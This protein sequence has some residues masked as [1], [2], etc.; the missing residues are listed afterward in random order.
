MECPTCNNITH[1]VLKIAI[2]KPAGAKKWKCD[3]CNY[4][5]IAVKQPDTEKSHSQTTNM[6]QQSTDSETN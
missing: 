5:W 3:T 1:S 6:E 2:T 4:S